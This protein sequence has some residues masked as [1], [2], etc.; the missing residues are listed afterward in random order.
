[1][2]AFSGSRKEFGVVTHKGLMGRGSPGSPEGGASP[3]GGGSEL[4]G[5]TYSHTKPKLALQSASSQRALPGFSTAQRCA[6]GAFGAQK[7]NRLLRCEPVAVP[8]QNCSPLSD[9]G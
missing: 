4:V 6:A 9:W 8:A 1:M 3:P 7:E 5:V 2:T